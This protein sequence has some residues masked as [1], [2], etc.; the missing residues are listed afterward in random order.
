MMYSYPL[1]P[2]L[3]MNMHL[4]HPLI[5]PQPLPYKAD[6]ENFL[7]ISNQPH[8]ISIPYYL[9]QILIYHNFNNVFEVN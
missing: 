4:H 5:P 2:T 1:H 7:L 6:E 9:Y 3:L 8:L